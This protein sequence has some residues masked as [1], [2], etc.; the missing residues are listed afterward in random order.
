MSIRTTI[1]RWLSAFIISSLFAGTGLAHEF[2]I[3]PTSYRVGE[4]GHLEAYL[5]NGEKFVGSPSY[6][7]SSETRRFDL[8]SGDQITAV[9]AR[10]GDSPAL[11][12]QAPQTGLTIVVHQKTTSVLT[13]SKWKKFQGFA[14]HKDFPNVLERHR[15]RSLSEDYFKEAY[16]RFS[17]SLIAVGDGV[18]SDRITGL[19]IELVALQNPYT[20]DLSGGLKVIAYYQ[21]AV[22]PDAQI[23]LFEK[24]PDNKVE[25]TLHRTD[26][27]G[28]VVLPVQS[29]H[30]YL[31]DTVVLR[32]PSKELA[33]E[34]SV[35]WETL[36]ASLTFSVGSE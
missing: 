16:T 6:Y 8:V 12:M 3:E 23:E 25:I 26:D 10:E 5:R 27:Q 28:V 17:K 19:E 14:D 32:E 24:S 35:V 1:S 30:R 20:D 31:V 22:H 15:A 11:K 9:T 21:N 36:W 18:G 4:Q 34:K 29:S 13:Y 2:W 7:L 33:G